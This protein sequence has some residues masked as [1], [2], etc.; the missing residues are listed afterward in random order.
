MSKPHVTGPIRV[1]AYRVVER[2]VEDG[3]ASGWYRAHKYTEN[4]EPEAIKDAIILAVMSS[5]SEW[6]WFETE[7]S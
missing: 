5:L 4:P 7:Q 3:V 1:N 2:A 6:L